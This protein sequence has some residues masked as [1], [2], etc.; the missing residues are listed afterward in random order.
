VLR[1]NNHRTKYVL[2]C[3]AVSLTCMGDEP[4]AE[5]VSKS[6]KPAEARP[7]D[8][9]KLIA[10][11]PSQYILGIGDQITFSSSEVEE[12]AGKTVRID[13]QGEINLPLVGRLKAAGL[14]PKQLEAD[15][16]RQFVAFFQR[17]AISITV[18][19]FASQPVSVIG[20]VN[21]PGVH[22]LRGQ[23]TLVE[24]LSKAGGLRQDA[25]NTIKITRRSSSGPIPVST[26]RSDLSGDFSVAEL[27]LRSV[28]EAR[29]PTENIMIR[30]ND[31]ISIP[32]A[33]MVYVVGEVNRAGGFVLNERDSISVLQ[34]LSL[35]GG[36]SHS[37]A[38]GNAKIL[39]APETGSKRVEIDANLKQILAGKAKDIEM[40][41][42]DIL[43]IP[44]SSSKKLGIRTAEVVVQTLSGVV[45]WR[46]GR[47]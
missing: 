18:S 33:E 22:Q 27:S 36:L 21:T 40:L 12:V 9:A 26:A 19:E 47:F 39:R 5:N 42:D 16:S 4:Q 2:L 17:P 32:R 10:G 1:A 14:T 20:A 23:T 13:N 29:D 35:A 43:F 31:V 15:L 24:V 37:A 34:A 11:D 3:L 45:I 41:S 6:N 38:T 28:L 25:G 46:A 7:A 44:G 30:T 8:I